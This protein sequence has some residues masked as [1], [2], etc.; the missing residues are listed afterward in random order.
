MLPALSAHV[1]LKVAVVP[2]VFVAK[3]CIRLP[4]APVRPALRRPHT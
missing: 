3:S 2:D 1:P 4:D